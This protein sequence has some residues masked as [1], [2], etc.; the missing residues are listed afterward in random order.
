MLANLG[1]RKQVIFVQIKGDRAEN[2]WRCPDGDVERVHERPRMDKHTA[3][4]L[5]VRPS[6]NSG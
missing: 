2:F 5:L 4:Y 1:G 3:D 6:L